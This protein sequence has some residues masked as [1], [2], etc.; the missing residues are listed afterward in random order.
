MKKII[1][2]DLYDTVLKLKD[3]RFTRR[4]EW[5]YQTYFSD[6]CTYEELLAYS[7]E[8]K[9]YGLGRWGEHQQHNSDITVGLAMQF[10]DELIR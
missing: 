5:L 3:F 7:K 8:K 1:V 2:L 10:A 9:V 4:I 6:A